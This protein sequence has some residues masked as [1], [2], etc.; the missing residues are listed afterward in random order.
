MRFLRAVAG[1]ALSLAGGALAACTPGASQ[2][3]ASGGSGAAASAFD[4]RYVASGS[5]VSGSAGCF[6]MDRPLSITLTVANGQAELPL[7]GGRLAGTMRGPVGADGS[8]DALRW[9]GTSGV[10]VRTRGRIGGTELMLELAYDYA[11]DGASGCLYRY[12]GS[13]A[14]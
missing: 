10:E 7:R 12:A 5:L 1:V 4:G 11:A 13:R 8:L 14:A 3:V 6:R 2:G 9:D